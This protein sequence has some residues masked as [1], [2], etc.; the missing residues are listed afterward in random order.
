MLSTHTVPANVIVLT[1]L[2][3]VV[4][5]A[6]VAAVAV[7]ARNK[8]QQH[9]APLKVLANNAFGQRRRLVD[10]LRGLDCV[11]VLQDET[12]VHIN[13]PLLGLR[14]CCTLC[15]VCVAPST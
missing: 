12:P 7:A 8:R 5:V 14:L 6:I 4:V 9:Q 1:E 15:T 13:E 3:V 11:P 10:F 2:L